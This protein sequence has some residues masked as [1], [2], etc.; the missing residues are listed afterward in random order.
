MAKIV[1]AKKPEKTTGKTNR[2][3]YEFTVEGGF[4]G[5]LLSM[6]CKIVSSRA[7]RNKELSFD[8]LCQIIACA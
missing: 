2:V 8:I 4:I 5:T 3:R 6:Q 7:G 1:G